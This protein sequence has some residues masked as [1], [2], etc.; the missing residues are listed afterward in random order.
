MKRLCLYFAFIILSLNLCAAPVDPMTAAKVATNFYRQQVTAKSL[1][2]Q[3]NMPGLLDVTA[4]TPYQ[5]IYVFNAADGN[6]FVLVAGDD[7]SIPVLGYSDKGSFDYNEMPDN[8]RSWI[9]HYEQEIIYII[10][11]NATSSTPASSE[12]ETLRNG[13]LLE[14]KGGSVEPL[15]KTQWAQRNH[16]NDG[17]VLY[18]NMCPYDEAAGEYTLAGCVATSMAQIMKHWEYPTHGTG[19][20]SYTV[21]AHPEYGEQSADFG[22]TTYAWANMPL[23]LTSSSTEAEKNAVAL[24]MYHCG[25]ACNMNY[26]I[27]SRGGSLAHITY[28]QQ[29]FTQYFGYS[30]QIQYVKKSN[31]SDADW[32]A[33]IKQELDNNRPCLYQG[34]TSTEINSMGHA[35]VCDGY[36]SDNFF[37]FNWGW[38]GRE[39]GYFRL[40]AITPLNYNFSYL[41]ACLIGIE[42]KDNTGIAENSKPTCA[43]YPNPAVEIL[44]ITIDEGTEVKTTE[45]LNAA[46]QLLRTYNGNQ[47]EFHVGDLPSGLYFMRVVTSEGVITKKWVK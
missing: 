8:A 41:Q 44:H 2:K 30:S 5:H 22:A 46:G 37:H 40:D 25:V 14:T 4:Q 7:R 23:T 19:T 12:W 29:P 38:S 34:Q 13:G 3:Q 1:L 26:D 45:I 9:N 17:A 33:L 36:N 24:L 10:E 27:R 15:I 11:H 18:N 39:D 32:L 6:G 42:P 21:T 47:R 16:S 28:A 31:Y 20:H 43:L 35:F